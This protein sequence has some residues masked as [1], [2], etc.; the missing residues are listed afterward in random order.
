MK[1]ADALDRWRFGNLS[2]DFVDVTML[3]NPLSSKLM[4]IAA[5]LQH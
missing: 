4:P 2:E 3:R 1:D 5:A